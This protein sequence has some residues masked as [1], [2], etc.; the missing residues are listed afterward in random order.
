MKTITSLLLLLST[1]LFA[2]NYQLLPDT[3]THCSYIYGD[4]MYNQYEGHYTLLPEDDTLYQGNLYMKLP[5]EFSYVEDSVFAVRQVGDKVFGIRKSDTINEYL[6][7]D[8]ESP[9]GDTL[10]NLYSPNGYYAAVVVSDDSSLLNDASYHHF[11]E[12]YAIGV[13]LNGVLNTNHQWSFTWQERGICSSPGGLLYN[14]IPLSVSGIPPYDFLAHTPDPRYNLALYVSGCVFTGVFADLDENDLNP[15]S[16]YPNPSTGIFN[17]RDLT[18][19]ISE[20]E[21]F[22]LKGNSL[23]KTASVGSSMDISSF[24]NGVYFLRVKT[25][26]NAYHQAKIIKAE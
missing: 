12:M 6:I 25:A 16:I 17:I 3:C 18:M 1:N 26:D 13:Y 11:R 21:I 23:L 8:W 2:Q 20:I 24:E 14:H 7:Q 4:W 9:V 22:D 19:D 15:I 10:Y 5:I